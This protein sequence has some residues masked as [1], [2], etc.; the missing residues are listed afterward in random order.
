MA[1]RIPPACSR[2]AMLS[3]FAAFYLAT[4]STSLNPT[5]QGQPGYVE[6]LSVCIA[7]RGLSAETGAEFRIRRADMQAAQKS[8]DQI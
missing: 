8:W 4:C 1:P 7:S 5:S 2:A 3:C 6:K